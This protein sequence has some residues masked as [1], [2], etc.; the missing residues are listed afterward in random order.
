MCFG[1]DCSHR[2]VYPYFFVQKIN[3]LISN[4]NNGHTDR[5]WVSLW[6]Q[7]DVRHFQEPMT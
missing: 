2:N 5:E 6:S 7:Y 1:A 3:A 4:N